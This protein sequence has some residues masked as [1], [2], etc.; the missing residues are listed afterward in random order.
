VTAGSPIA[1]TLIGWGFGER[2]RDRAPS[3]RS[4]L[5]TNTLP[6]DP[7]T[8]DPGTRVDYDAASQ[9]DFYKVS[10]PAGG[11]KSLGIGW[12]LTGGMNRSYDVGMRFYFCA[13]TDASCNNPVRSQFLGYASGTDYPW[14]SS[15]A[16]PVGPFQVFTFDQAAGKFDM[17]PQ[18]CVCI[19]SAYTGAGFFYVEVQAQDRTSYSDTTATLN[20]PVGAYPPSGSSCP[21]PCA[22]VSKAL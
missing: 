15:L 18:M 8:H 21:S 7:V 12:G 14:Y 11:D 6:D 2:T 10:F 22:F 3:S 13:N 19:D 16:A 4:P 17:N 20:L 1:S 9:V 5:P